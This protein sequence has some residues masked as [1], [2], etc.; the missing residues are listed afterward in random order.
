MLHVLQLRMEDDPP[1]GDD[2]YFVRT[3]DDLKLGPMHG[4][5]HS[6]PTLSH[7]ARSRL[8]PVPVFGLLRAHVPRA[9]I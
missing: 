1:E 2:G 9:S 7:D 4:A 8:T 3:K 5:T 6:H